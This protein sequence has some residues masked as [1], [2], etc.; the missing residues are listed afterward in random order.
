VDALGNPVASATTT[1]TVA[2]QQ[3]PAAGTLAGATAADA[4]MGVATFSDLRID[5]AGSP[6]VLRASTGLEAPSSVLFDPT[7]NRLWVGDTSN[8]R[9]LRYDG[10]ATPVAS[11]QAAVD[12]LG[13]LDGPQM[14]L[15]RDRPN[16]AP[17]AQSFDIVD[18][19][20]IDPVAHRAFVADTA[21]ARVLVF[22]LSASNELVGGIPG[23]E[24]RRRL[25]PRADRLPGQLV[26]RRQC[27]PL[28][29]PGA[30]AR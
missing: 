25:R 11:G 3:N 4:V 2:I 27:E 23:H 10:T 16:D 30:A 14:E 15:S 26:R 21:N 18:D 8:H 1:F 24:Q 22:N 29:R 6:Y 5:R 12:G 17:N 19:V 13:H 9:V 7:S 28:L 20:A